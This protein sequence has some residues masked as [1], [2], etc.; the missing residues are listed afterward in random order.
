[1]VRQFRSFK[2]LLMLQSG[3]NSTF[4]DS[5]VFVHLG[6]FKPQPST[7]SACSQTIYTNS[8][9]ITTPQDITTTNKSNTNETTKLNKTTI[10]C[11][12]VL[13]DNY[14]NSHKKG[15]NIKCILCKL[16]NE[17]LLLI[18]RTTR[19]HDRLGYNKPA[20]GSCVLRAS[21]PGPRWSCHGRC[22][23]TCLQVSFSPVQVQ[24]PEV[25][26]TV[27]AASLSTPRTADTQY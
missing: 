3:T 11:L 4:S 12:N 27:P 10:W 16:S 15:Y 5:K 2:A 18:F 9:V 13:L 21:L 26:H 6:Y 24:L 19:C 7:C 23:T 14:E 25:F 17:V 22:F 8:Q 1:M 20:T